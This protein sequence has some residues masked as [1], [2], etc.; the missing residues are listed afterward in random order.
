MM[1]YA[2]AS[3]AIGLLVYARSGGPQRRPRDTAQQA[4]EGCD[5]LVKNADHWIDLLQM[6]DRSLF[7]HLVLCWA[8]ELIRGLVSISCDVDFR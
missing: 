6:I 1:S 4:T 8:N 3:T 7:W 5:G 2:V